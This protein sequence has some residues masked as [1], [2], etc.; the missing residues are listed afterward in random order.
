MASTFV[1]HFLKKFTNGQKRNIQH[2]KVVPKCNSFIVCI[3]HQVNHIIAILIVVVVVLLK[4]LDVQ[5]REDTVGLIFSSKSAFDRLLSLWLGPIIV[6]IITV[7]VE[8]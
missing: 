3:V 4:W 6:L 5:N 1:F 7:I 8:R 2:T